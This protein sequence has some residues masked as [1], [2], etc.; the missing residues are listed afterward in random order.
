MV[1]FDR[2]LLIPGWDQARLRGARVAVCGADWSATF[3][4]WALA[5]MGIGEIVWIGRAEGPRAMLADWFL[6]EPSPFPGVKVSNY[7]LEVEY[8]PELEWAVDGGAAA[9]VA[10]HAGPGA[11]AAARALAARQGIPLASG[12]AE[13][14]GWL[15]LGAPAQPESGE[16]PAIAMLVAALL[17]DS[18]REHLCPLW[19]GT[20]P[21]G[22]ALGFEGGSFPRGLKATLVGVGGIGVYAATA[23][24]ALG[25]DL[26]LVDFD[27][28]EE[29]NLNRQGLFGP[30]DAAAREFKAVA[31]ARSLLHFF[32]EREFVAHRQRIPRVAAPRLAG[33]RAEVLLSAVDNAATRLALSS[34]ALELG[35]PLIQGGTDVFMADCYTQDPAGVPLDRQ[36]HGAMAEAA[37]G[38]TSR[39]RR[40]GGCAENPSY[41]VPGMTAGALMALR[42]PDVAKGRRDCPPLHWR[43]GVLPV[44]RR[45]HGFDFECAPG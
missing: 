18:V 32:P 23:A 27:R 25:A 3:T 20:A 9:I 24:A 12:S 15:G 33:S 42:L 5:S 2:Q 35:V 45:D 13:C 43:S 6:T 10:A 39:P 41:V 21:P 7:P 36:M 19:G 17:A 11:F 14:G 38:E 26:A 1:R 29:T 37:A 40:R 28:V 31:A 30:A 4:V 22:G 8:G 34:A 16:H 44:E